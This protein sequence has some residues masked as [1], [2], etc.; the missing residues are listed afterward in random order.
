MPLGELAIAA[1]IAANLVRPRLSNGDGTWHQNPIGI[2]PAGRLASIVL[3]DVLAAPALTA[4]VDLVVRW[5]R[6]VGV[7]RQQ[8]KSFGYTAILLA[9]ALVP[10]SGLAGWRA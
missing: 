7:E 10:V 6:S 2:V 3:M 5:R 1:D 8:M 9:I 4:A